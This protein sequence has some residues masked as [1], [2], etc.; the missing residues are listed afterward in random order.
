MKGEGMATMDAWM[1][2]LSHGPI[3]KDFERLVSAQGAP[4]AAAYPL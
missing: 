2:G 4:G 3:G 1:E